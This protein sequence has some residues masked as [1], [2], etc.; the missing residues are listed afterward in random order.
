MV[1]AMNK[2]RAWFDRVATRGAVVLAAMMTMALSPPAM[3]EVPAVPDEPVGAE[4]S[5]QEADQIARVLE[6]LFDLF[7]AR[8]DTCATLGGAIHAYVDANRVALKAAASLEASG[9]KLPAAVEQR[10]TARLQGALGAIQKCAAED[11]V[12]Q[13]M[14]RVANPDLPAP[15]QA[16]PSVVPPVAADLATYTKGLRGKG[17]L[18]AT[19]TT[20][21]G[22]ITCRLLPDQAPMTVANFVGLA[23]GK[24]PW[25]DPR[26]STVQKG[27]PYYDGLV[28]HRVIADFM[29]QGGDPLGQGT[30][31]PGYKFADERN[32]LSMKP[33]TLAMANAGPNSN[34]GQF[35]ITDASPTHLDGKHTIF[36]TCRPLT[37]IRKIA[38]SK[39]GPRDRPESPVTMK[40]K[41]S[42]G[43]W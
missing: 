10:I 17:E 5:A 25:M 29:I 36:G 13:A 11:D 2:S 1:R 12:Q 33:G 35:F 3:A 27:K 22:K 26:T 4:V 42:R 31:G 28:F 8:Q 24:K 34:G 16:D 15:T 38:R 40:V 7:V 43:R 19:F 20:S 6:G 9:R 23:T 39:T 21:R 32:D 37:V 18:L 30:G 14:L 41:I